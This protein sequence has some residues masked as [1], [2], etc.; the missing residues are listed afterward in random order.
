MLKLIEYLKKLEE[1]KFDYSKPITYIIWPL[2]F[3]EYPFPAWLIEE[4]KEETTCK[5][6]S[7][8]E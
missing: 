2:H 3:G 1:V 6:H 5:T 4:N 7:E 8:T